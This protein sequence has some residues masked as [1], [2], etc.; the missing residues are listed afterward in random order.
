MVALTTSAHQSDPMPSCQATTL[1][2]KPCKGRGATTVLV[3]TKGDGHGYVAQT[4]CSKHV[5]MLVQAGTRV[6]RFSKESAMNSFVA[7]RG[8]K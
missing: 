3:S 8:G 2:G 5:A 6:R 1:V 7:Q 4:L